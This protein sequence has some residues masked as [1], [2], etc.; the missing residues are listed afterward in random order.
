MSEA[1]KPMLDL[2]RG[3]PV[4]RAPLWL[5]RQAGRY[6]PEYRAL[7]SKAED[8]LNLCLTPEWATEITLQP[9]RRFGFDAAIIFADILL[10]PL[11]L[12]Q[13]LEFRQGEGPVLEPIEEKNFS[14]HFSY[15]EDKVAAVF[16]TVRLVKKQLPSSTSLIGF[17][18]SPWTVACYMID[19]TSRTGFTEAKLWAKEKT[20]ALEILIQTLI[21][22]SDRY[23]S[24]Q[25]EAG[26]DIIQLFDS[27]SGLLEGEDFQRWIIEPTRQLVARINEKYPH[28]PVI[29]FP[30]EAGKHYIDY[31]HKTG[32]DGVSIDQSVDLNYAR[33]ELRPI[34][35][36]QGNLDP[37]LLVEG[38]EAMQ[39]GARKILNALGP[40]HIFNLGHG[41]LQQTPVEHVSDL[42]QFVRNWQPTG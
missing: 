29:G 14:S 34:K 21:G 24:A 26:A 8:F 40:N 38:G 35:L 17:C 4:S 6:L 33:S 1:V 32:V 36:L 22:A 3:K 9:I 20:P 37:E 25:I 15:S 11:A 16:E 10:I 42:V 39:E 5:M 23:L 19:G 30:R 7:R 13:K 31:C 12:G 18:G 41:V 28:V 2:L 27:W